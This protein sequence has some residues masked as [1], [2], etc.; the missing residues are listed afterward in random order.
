M[1]GGALLNTENNKQS[2]RS[3]KIARRNE[4]KMLRSWG[5]NSS[6]DFNFI[7]GLISGIALTIVLLVVFAIFF[8]F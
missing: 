1:D 8:H 2:R 5:K 6:A 3:A 7:I 4:E